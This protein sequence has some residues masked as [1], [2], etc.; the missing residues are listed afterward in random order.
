MAGRRQ[1]LD[2]PPVRWRLT[3]VVLPVPPSPTRT[4]LKVGIEACSSEVEGRGR[5]AAAQAGKREGE[6]RRR[7]AVSRCVRR[8]LPRETRVGYGQISLN[9][10]RP[11]FRVFWG[12]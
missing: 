8:R 7:H 12:V 6:E 5:E 11:F 9:G 1:Q 10:P 4:S 2:G 3:K